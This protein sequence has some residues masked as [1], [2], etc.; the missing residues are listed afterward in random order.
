M[1]AIKKA[2]Q[3]K[4][5]QLKHNLMSEFRNEMEKLK[6]QHKSEMETQKN[7]LKKTF[8][9]NKNFV[10]NKYT[11]ELEELKFKKGRFLDI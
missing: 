3:K 6:E 7:K 4:I 9:F 1:K 5:N 10:I 8:E 11:K 2:N